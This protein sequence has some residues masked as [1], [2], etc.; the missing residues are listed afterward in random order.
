M[1]ELPGG[2]LRALQAVQDGS[3]RTLVIAGPE[4]SGKSDLLEVLVARLESA[5]VR[6][7]PLSASYRERNTPYAAV[8]PLAEGPPPTDEVAEGIPASAEESSVLAYLPPSPGSSRRSRGERQRGSVM[9]VPYA[10][11]ARGVARLDAREYWELLCSSFARTK[12]YRVAVTLEDGAFADDESRDVLLYLSHRARLRPFLL[13]LVL[14]SSLPAF[15]SWEERL[16]GRPDVDWVR[17]L[18][19]RLDPREAA[20]VKRAVDD[21]RPPTRRLL[22]H[23]ALLGGSVSEVQLARI[24]RCTFQ[25]LAEALLP[26]AEAR[27]VRVDAGKVVIPH[28][29]WIRHLPELLPPSEVRRMHGEIAEALEAM[30]PE[31]SLALRRQ[32]A[33]H[34]FASDPGPVALRYLL[35]CAELA[36]RLNAFDDV[37]DLLAKSLACVGSLPQADR[38]AAEA[39]LRLFRARVLFLSGRAGEAERQLDA[40]LGVSMTGGVPSSRLDEWVEPLL[41][42]LQAVGPRPS[43]LTS[44][45]ELVDR[46]GAGGSA[47]TAAMLQVVLTEAELLRGRSDKSRTESQRTGKMAW[48]HPDAPLEAVALLAVGL[49]QSDGSAAE[50]STA[51]RFLQS[52]AIAFTHLRRPELEQMAVE[53]RARLLHREGAHEAVLALHMRAIPVLQRLGLPSL[54]ASHELGVAELLFDRAPEARGTRALRRAR[55][56]VEMLRLTPPSAALLRLWLL[57]GRQAAYADDVEGA[58]ERWSAVADRQGPPVLGR[59]RSEALVRLSALE[60]LHGRSE[61]AQTR[62]DRPEV[63]DL[64]PAGKPAWSAWSS[65]VRQLGPAAASGAAALRGLVPPPSPAP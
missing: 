50:R 47:T 16:S 22:L 12:G 48:T 54:E 14:D 19:S 60:L 43:L 65:V 31:P 63:A 32:L 30:H 53:Y 25:E 45:G 34:Q 52:A 42:A 35:E 17:T 15:S 1:D 55:E 40:G 61:E 23:T 38:A 3:G 9:G 27:L 41:P 7:Q 24:A 62:F 28:P 20:R 51:D 21:L 4:A 11:R 6:V 10:V 56:L 8:A 13:V 64:F 58:R 2:L 37:D 33:E 39:E 57:E 26:A 49:A 18:S 46:L 5:G 44:L 59:L 36:V 29:A